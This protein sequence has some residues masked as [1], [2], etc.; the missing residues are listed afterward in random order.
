[1]TLQVYSQTYGGKDAGEEA[2]AGA[3]GSSIER[4]WAAQ[5]GSGSRPTRR[6]PHF[7]QISRTDRRESQMSKRC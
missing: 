1:M 7:L 5:V 2:R 3:D 4:K 6:S